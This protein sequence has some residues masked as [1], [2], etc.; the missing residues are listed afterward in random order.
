[1]QASRPHLQE[2]CHINTGTVVDKSQGDLYLLA[3]ARCPSAYM[4]ET[5][6][7]GL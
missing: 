1:M 2:L 6:D 3:L 7:G 4:Y 5:G